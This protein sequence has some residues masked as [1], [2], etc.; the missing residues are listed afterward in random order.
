MASISPAAVELARSAIPETA[1]Q[2]F[3][4]GVRDDSSTH[5]SVLLLLAEIVVRLDRIEALL[6]ADETNI[7]PDDELGLP[8]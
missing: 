8:S 5:P 3:W 1:D 2:Q 4:A 7:D 6:A